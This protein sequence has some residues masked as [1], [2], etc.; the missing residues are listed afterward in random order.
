MGLAQLQSWGR[1]QLLHD[2]VR[3]S[4]SSPADLRRPDVNAVHVRRCSPVHPRRLRQEAE[5]L[6]LGFRSKVLADT[7]HPRTAAEELTRALQEPE[8]REW[9]QD[10]IAQL[11]AVFGS[12]LALPRVSAKLEVL[13]G[14]PCP[15][16]HA[17]HVGV[18]CLVTYL[19]P[20]TEVVENR[21]VK[22]RWLWDGEGG[23]AVGAVEPAAPYTA[24]GEADLLFL[25]G[26]AAPGNYGM[27]AVHRSP[28]M[29]GSS[30]SG[31]SSSSSSGG[32]G[33]DGG[34]STSGAG[35]R[36]VGSSGKA[37]GE[38]RAA[39]RAQAAA[40]SGSQGG[41]GGGG[42]DDA[43]GASGS[44][45]GGGSGGGRVGAAATGPPPLR[46]LL[47]IDDV[48]AWAECGCGQPHEGEAGAGAHLADA[49]LTVA[50]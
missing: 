27:G 13:A 1:A 8:V 11:L 35:A 7:R 15:R 30:S 4:T 22:R 18:R 28:D 31:S 37:A 32:G 6:G 25:K 24:A 47:T 23:V 5:R 16:W 20:G 41:G 49:S 36:P 29:G 34:C 9:L 40:P 44:A 46:L 38:V 17:D 12:E 19:G 21:H 26:H 43:A 3:L 42:L 48:V 33:G 10:D 50:P 14:T 45:L 39:G 2:R